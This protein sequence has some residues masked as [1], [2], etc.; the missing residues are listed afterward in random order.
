MPHSTLIATLLGNPALFP[1]PAKRVQLCE[2][3]ISWILLAGRYAYKIKKPVD[4]GFLDFSDSAKRRFFCLEELR[5]NRRLAASMYIDVLPI[6]GRP[7]APVFGRQPAFEFAVVMRRFGADKTL[8]ALLKRDRL[9]A[10]VLDALACKVAAFH[11]GLAPDQSRPISNG[12]ILAQAMDNFSQLSSLLSV[13]DQAE[14]SRLRNACQ[15]QFE[16]HRASFEQRW[17]QGM[18]RECHGDLH[19]GNLVML[20]GVPT[21]FDGIE[22]SPELRWIDV[23]SDIA[24]L[25]MDLLRRQR[26]DLAYRFLNAYLQIG[27]DYQGVAVLRFYLGYRAMV[28]AKVAALQVRQQPTADFTACR[29][30][31]DLTAQIFNPQ[32]PALLITHGLPGCGKTTLSQSLLERLPAIRLRS[33]IER[34]RLYGEAC[35]QLYSTQATEHTYRHLLAQSRLLLQSGFSVIVD[36]A[37][38]KRRERAQFRAL[39]RQLGL[40]MAILSIQLDEASSVQRLKQRQSEGRDASDADE[41]VYRMLRVVAEPLTNE[42]LLFAVE[43][44]NDGDLQDMAEWRRLYAE[45]GRILKLDKA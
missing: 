31:L 16:V 10:S 17:Q 7:E 33:D 15:K 42:E 23:I 4:F 13:N 24:F 40:P 44:V 27:G 12:T 5:L 36:A 8:D 25:V 1:H 35:P 39:A 11:A 37:F 20:R 43:W 6:G 19:L 14:L 28:R 21:P 32:R 30:Y 18:I 22:F 9:P 38:L 3:H 45:L 2:T 26:T 29:H 41:S 34:K